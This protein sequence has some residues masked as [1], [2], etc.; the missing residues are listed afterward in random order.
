MRASLNEAGYERY[1]EVMS[2]EE[3]IFAEGVERGELAP[4]DPEILAALFSGMVQA[5]IAQWVFGLDDGGSSRV[6]EVFPAAKLHDMIDRAF[7][8]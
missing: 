8:A 2:F 7:R 4:E 5:Y 3:R 6:D 1:R